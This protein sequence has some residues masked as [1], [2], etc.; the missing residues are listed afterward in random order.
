MRMTSNFLETKQE[1][2]EWSKYLKCWEQ[3]RKMLREKPINIEFCI[4][5]KIILQK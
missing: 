1:R 2:R 3:I 5:C 4:L